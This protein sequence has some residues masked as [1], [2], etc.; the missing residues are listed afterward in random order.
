MDERAKLAERITRGERASLGERTRIRERATSG[1]RTT[2]YERAT[3]VERTKIGRLA[4]LLRWARQAGAVVLLLVV[5]LV[6]YRLGATTILTV[7]IGGACG[8]LVCLDTPP[9]PAATAAAIPSSG[10]GLRLTTVTPLGCPSTAIANGSDHPGG[11]WIGLRVGIPQPAAEQANCICC[12]NCIESESSATYKI[13]SCTWAAP[14]SAVTKAFQSKLRGP[15]SFFIRAVSN[16][17][18]AIL[19]FE[20]LISSLCNFTTKN[21]ESPTI[22]PATP[23]MASEMRITS[24]Q[25]WSERPQIIFTLSE[26]IT[27]GVVLFSCVEL[28]IIALLFLH[29]LLRRPPC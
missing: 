19:S 20:S 2:I 13:S 27:I 11:R 15:N 6:P 23:T 9:N 5:L 4:R 3:G 22:N 12:A 10:V 1:E 28:L 16:S 17:A 18:A 7:P 8:P 21:V 24:S 25:P 29:D 14:L 26:K